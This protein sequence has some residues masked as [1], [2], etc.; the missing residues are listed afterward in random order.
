M[1]RHLITLCAA[2]AVVCSATPLS[3]QTAPPLG[4]APLTRI[5]V[6]VRDVAKA[7]Q[8]YADIFQL[9][10]APA[11]TTVTIPLA[12]GNTK[13]KRAVVVLP[14]VRLEVDQPDG[15]GPAADY[16]KK[17]GQG[18]YRV[19]FS[20]TDPI[21]P[22]VAQLQE[23]GGTL[24][25]GS[26]TGSFAW[27]DLSVTLGT[28]IDLQQEAG[29][30][31]ASATPPVGDRVVL[32]TTPLSH[33]GWAVTNAD[34]VAKSFADVLGITMPTVRDYK[35]VE[36]PPNYP[37]DANATLRLTSWK[38]ENTGIELIQSLGQTN[39]TDF[40]GKH[41]KNSAPQHLAFPVGDRLRETVELFQKKGA[42]WTNGKVGGTYEYLDFTETLGIIF[43]LNGAWK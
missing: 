14:N 2:I 9:A 24:T 12:K 39:W 1:I 27:V 13:V 19:G 20:T 18:I 15:K 17:F 28:T 3:A 23:R 37:A 22:K 7:A 10:A 34:Y 5:G 35:P 6:V 40:V 4:N 29:P 8:V 26:T 32:G 25:A 41:G 11:V 36:I 30:A 42:S 31:P 43:E 38:Q 16:L 21:G 33:L